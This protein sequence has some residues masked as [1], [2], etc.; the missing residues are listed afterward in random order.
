[1]EREAGEAVPDGVI[2]NEWNVFD[3]VALMRHWHWS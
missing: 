1:M 3:G 2:V